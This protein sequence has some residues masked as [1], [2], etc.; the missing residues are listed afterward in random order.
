MQYL[1]NKKILYRDIKPENILI[2]REEEN[3]HN[4]HKHRLVIG[5]GTG[6]CQLAA[7][8]NCGQIEW[9]RCR[10]RCVSSKLCSV[11][12]PNFTSRNSHRFTGTFS[13]RHAVVHDQKSESKSRFSASSTHACSLL[14]K[15]FFCRNTLPAEARQP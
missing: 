1:H 3:G 11:P 6:I 5:R 7:G 10:A 12:T 4:W 15:R 2:E 13:H 9:S 14:L 8:R